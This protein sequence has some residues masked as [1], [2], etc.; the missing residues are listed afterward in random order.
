MTK[1]DIVKKAVS[2]VVAAG[3]SVIV[4][5]IIANNVNIEKTHQKVTVPIAAI[6]IGGVVADASSDW[7]DNKID[8]IAEALSSV[9]SKNSEK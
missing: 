7:T 5:Q 2:F 9:F 6:A 1:L 4:N 3:T 8:E